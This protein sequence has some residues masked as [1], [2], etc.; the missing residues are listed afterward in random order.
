MRAF[1]LEIA[2]Q[3][4]IRGG[5]FH[6]LP[7]QELTSR[8]ATRF[9]SRIGHLNPYTGALRACCEQSRAA[10]RAPELILHRRQSAEVLGY[11]APSPFS[12]PFAPGLEEKEHVVQ[13]LYG[14]GK[15]QRIQHVLH[16]VQLVED[17]HDEK[18]LAVE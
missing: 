3:A 13:L 7:C 12:L 8:F 6:P 11:E 14:Y 4:D 17:F 5:Y 9:P 18:R 2:L 10:I 16:D 15:A 1:H